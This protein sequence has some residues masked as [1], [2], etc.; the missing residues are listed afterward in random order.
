MNCQGSIYPGDT[1][2]GKGIEAIYGF[3]RVAAV[4]GFYLS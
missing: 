3:R 2:Q 4:K 1:A